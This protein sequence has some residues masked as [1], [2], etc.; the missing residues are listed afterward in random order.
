MTARILRGMAALHILG[1]G[2]LRL[3]LTGGRDGDRAGMR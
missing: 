3:P 1:L 2:A